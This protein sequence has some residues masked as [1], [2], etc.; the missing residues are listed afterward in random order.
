MVEPQTPSRRTQPNADIIPLLA[1]VWSTRLIQ[2]TGLHVLSHVHCVDS[3]G[4][5]LSRELRVQGLLGVWILR[6]KSKPQ[7]QMP[8]WEPHLFAAL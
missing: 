4:L 7:L 5:D 8:Q 3:I 1:G 6:A 2:Q